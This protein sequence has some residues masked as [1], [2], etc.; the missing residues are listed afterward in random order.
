MMTI[1]ALHPD[2]KKVIAAIDFLSGTGY[3]MTGLDRDIQKI[4]IKDPSNALT[5][6]E[7][8]PVSLK[9]KYLNVLTTDIYNNLYH[10]DTEIPEH[11][12]SYKQDGFIA[13]LSKAN[14]GT[15][16]WEDGWQFLGTDDRTGKIIVRKKTLNFWVEQERVSLLNDGHCMVKVEKECRH[17]NNYFYYA[18]GNTDRT[19]VDG[20]DGQSIRFYWN[21]HPAV[22]VSYIDVV[23]DVLNAKNILF[24]T[25][26][27]SDPE[28]YSRSDAAVLYIDRSQLDEVLAIIPQLYRA[29]QDGIKQSTPMF[30]KTLL[31]GLG[32]AEDPSNGLSFGISRS[33]LI[34]EALYDCMLSGINDK[35]QMADALSN[36]FLKVGISATHPYAAAGNVK[37]YENIINKYIQ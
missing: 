17:L 8:T 30:V 34:A 36:T 1:T 27:L 12:L 23:T 10:A 15:G 20:Y 32:L 26:V 4:K 5:D 6:E 33:K 19:R 29:V 22:A 2:I 16:F 24:T 7:D 37:M 28:A 25:K 9:Q 11:G 35:E 14:H 18:Y 31:P 3:S 21:L 13:A